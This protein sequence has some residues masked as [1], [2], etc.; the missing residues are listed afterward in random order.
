M[1][2]HVAMQVMDHRIDEV[3]EGTDP[4]DILAQAK[5][6]VERELGWKGLFLKIMSPLGFG[7]E[8]VRRYNN[9]TAS[10]Y[11]IPQTPEDFLQLAEDLGYITPLAE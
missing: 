5:A 4:E 8:V 3:V 6:R 7:Q 11:E 9:A 2:V 1:K 10:E